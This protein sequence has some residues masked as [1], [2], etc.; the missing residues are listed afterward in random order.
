MRGDGTEW[1]TALC[2]DGLTRDSGWHAVVVKPGADPVAFEGWPPGGDRLSVG[3][4]AVPGCIQPDTATVCPD[5]TSTC[6]TA[7]PACAH[8]RNASAATAGSPSRHAVD[9]VG[10]IANVV[11][12]SDA[13]RNVGFS[14]SGAVAAAFDNARLHV[15]TS[16]PGARLAV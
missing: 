9:V 16:S 1:V 2:T 11:A 6:D 12:A 3:A 14:L 10:D 13:S 5:T 15:V 8:A 7:T 4:V